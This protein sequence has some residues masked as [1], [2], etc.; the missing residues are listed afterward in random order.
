LRL[1]NRT[2]GRVEFLAIFGVE[3]GIVKQLL[4]FRNLGLQ[5][6]DRLRQ[7][8]QRMLLVEVQPAL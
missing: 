1:C 7:G 8:I 3:I 6:C 5:F 4:L 2:R